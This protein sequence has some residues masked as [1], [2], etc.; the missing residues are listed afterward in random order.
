VLPLTI[1]T[2]TSFFREMPRELDEAVR[3]DGCTPGQVFPS[4]IMPLA[5]PAVFTAGAVT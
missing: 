5:A 1:H 4:V 2:L 3:I